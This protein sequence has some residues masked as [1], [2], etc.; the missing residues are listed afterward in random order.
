[1]ADEK[2]LDSVRARLEIYAA[3]LVRDN[4]DA[5]DIVSSAF[6][7]LLQNPLVV[8][9]DR[10]VPYL[11][12]TV[13]N[14]CLNYRRDAARHRAA[15]S[16]IR[17]REGKAF[18]Y[19]STL[20]ESCDPSALFMSEISDICQQQIARMSDEVRQT[21]ALRSDGFSYKEIARQLNINENKVDKNLRKILALLRR[22]LSDYL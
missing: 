18:A 21:Y 5:R 3:Y 4:E 10:F 13:H 20:L 22:A 14:L 16:R 15:H 2:T 9:E 8:E 1:M 6:T 11:F 7:T 17:E 19:Y 12:R